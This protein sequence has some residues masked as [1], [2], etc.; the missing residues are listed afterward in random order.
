MQATLL[1]KKARD[2]F[3][4]LYQAVE[5]HA[6]RP[7]PYVFISQTAF[8]RAINS[9]QI[10]PQQYLEERL[11]PPFL[12]SLAVWRIGK[13]V[14]RFDPTLQEEL[15]KSVISD[16]P[17]EML[18]RL[19]VWAPYIEWTHQRKL[20]AEEEPSPIHGFFAS[21]EQDQDQQEYL[22]LH[23]VEEQ[24]V[25]LR[26]PLNLSLQE[27]LKLHIDNMQRQGTEAQNPNTPALLEAFQSVLGEWEA[28]ISGALSLLLYLC[29][30]QADLNKAAT[31]PTPQ[32]TKRGMRLFA[33]SG[34][35]IIETG[36][37]LGRRLRQNSNP[38]STGASV[39]PHLR[40]AHWHTYKVGPGRQQS[41]L[42]WLHPIL[43]GEDLPLSIRNVKPS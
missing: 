30:E 12:Q 10:T 40:R 25:S 23:F 32:K 27:A 33:A 26:L 14:F 18:Q 24:I 5:D 8:F 16:I 36:F 15:C 39:R 28:L 43:V 41:I 29:S 37:Q 34:E 31:N 21:I 1:L 3:P 2:A 13:Q 6:D 35:V 42:K 22:L 7:T 19:P 38:Q 4:N 20:F 9:L 17:G 11:S